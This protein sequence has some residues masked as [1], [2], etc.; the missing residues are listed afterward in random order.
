[1]RSQSLISILILLICIS[2]IRDANCQRMTR[3]VVVRRVRARPMIARSRVII[4]R[5]GSPGASGGSEADVSNEA[6][7]P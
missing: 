5:Q 7:V 2:L 4:I 6:I 3:V 1:M